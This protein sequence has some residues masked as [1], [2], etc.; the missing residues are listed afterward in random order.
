MLVG[1]Q[2]EAGAF[3][4]EAAQRLIAG[5]Q[6]H[7]YTTFDDLIEAV[8]R[9]D[10]E[11][12]LLPVENS[13]FGAIARAYDLLWQYTGLHI[14]D[15]TEIA[16]EMCLIGIP[17]TDEARIREVRSHPVALEQVRRFGQTHPNWR[18][19]AVA[20]TAGAVTEIMTLGDAAVAA[21]GPAFAAERYGATVLRRG[22]Q[23]DARNFTRFY[24]LSTEARPRA[25]TGRA[26]IGIEIDHRP[27]TLR[28]ALSAFADQSIDLRNIVARPNHVDPFHYRFFFELRDVEAN[29]LER[30][31]AN[32]A[33]STRIFGVY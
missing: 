3:S 11:A 22:I 31:L 14:I 16:V 4:D 20:D 1:F 23:D 29:R 30:A 8:D 17:G 24:L 15:E 10:V 26:V 6:T 9:R 7:G 2:G 18:Q 25:V 21:I 32:V 28:D 13:I 12:G 5:A 19:I 33:G 27:G